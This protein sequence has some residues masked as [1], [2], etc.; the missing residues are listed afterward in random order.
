MAKG[1]W[2]LGMFYKVAEEGLELG[3]LGILS[4]W[5]VCMKLEQVC[6]RKPRSPVT[7]VIRRTGF[8]DELWGV[9]RVNPELLNPKP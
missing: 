2:G 4:V 8:N 9:C 6:L 5:G 1:V 3:M 7:S